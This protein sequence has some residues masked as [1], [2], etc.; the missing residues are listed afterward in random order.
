MLYAGTDDGVYRLPDIDGSSEPTHVLES[1]RVMRVHDFDRV[2]GIF[3][4]AENGLYHTPN[5][6]DWDRLSSPRKKVYAV[7][8]SPDGTRLYAGTCPAHV[9]VAP[10]EDGVP[11]SPDWREL[12]GFQDL[13]SREE[14]YTPRHDDMAHLRT[15]ATHPDAPDRVVAGVEVGGVHVSEDRGATWT[16]RRDGTHDDVHELVVVGPDEYLT[17]T[18]FGLYHT[19]DAGRSWTRLDESVDQQYFRSAFAHDGTVYAGAG[20]GPSPTWDETPDHVF[21]VGPPD[22]L[23][24]VETPRPDELAIG[25]VLVDGD[26][27]AG[28]HHGTLLRGRGDEWVVVGHVPT[29][30]DLRGRYLPLEYVEE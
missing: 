23:R 24:P 5:G 7:G 6:D 9:Y 8:A 20:Q 26:V 17:A 13:P 15:L 18:G 29:P 22:D 14:W 10:I 28:T 21:L 27:V 19:T 2:D 3:A 4:A 25:W 30:G 11:R 12:A 1:G 16:E